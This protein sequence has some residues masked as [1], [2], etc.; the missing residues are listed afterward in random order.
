MVTTIPDKEIPF[1]YIFENEISY[2][3]G[4]ILFFV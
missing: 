3:G 1:S 4:C 2:L